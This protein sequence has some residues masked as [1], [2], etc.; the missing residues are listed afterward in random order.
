VQQLERH[1][2]EIVI[3]F[4]AVLQKISEQTLAALTEGQVTLQ[5]WRCVLDTIDCL[6]QYI[7]PEVIAAVMARRDNNQL[8]G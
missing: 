4:V 5:G 3:N 1:G 7:T 6:G 2:E 8:G